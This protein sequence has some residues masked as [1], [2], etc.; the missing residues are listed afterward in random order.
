MALELLGLC[1]AFKKKPGAARHFFTFQS[2]LRNGFVDDLT[3]AV[4]TAFR[5]N[6]V[7]H[8]GS[9]AVRAG[10]ELRDD[11]FIVGPSLITAL[12][13][14]LVFRMCHFFLLF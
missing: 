3:A 14:D 11:G 2:D 13:G 10:G 8:D 12:L 1:P 9:T 5:A 7:I 4:E 6:V